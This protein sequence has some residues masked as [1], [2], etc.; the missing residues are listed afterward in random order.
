[1]SELKIAIAGATGFVGTELCLKLLDQDFKLK[2]LSRKPQAWPIEHHHLTKLKGDVTDQEAMNELMKDTDILFY[3]VHGLKSSDKDFEYEEMKGSINANK[4]ATKHKLKKIIYLGGLGPEGHL[5]SHLRSRQLVGEILGS[6]HVPCL[7]FRASIVLGANS[8]SFEMMKAIA[9][10]LP[11]R[12]YAP[13]LESLCQPIGI[14]DLIKY[15]IEGIELKVNG[16]Q[17]VEIGSKEVIPYGELLDRF[18]KLDHL[19]RPKLLVSKVDQ[20]VITTLIDVVVP[21]FSQVGKKLFL[22]LQFPTV[23]TNSK[24]EEFF[25]NIQP[26][27]LDNALKLA[28]QKSLT[29]YPPLWGT[30]FWKELLEHYQIDPESG[31]DFVKRTLKKFNLWDKIKRKKA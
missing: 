27:S 29:H 1:M 8:T 26:M 12:P 22:S 2:I 16:H 5:S 11:V 31:K 14:D 17:I 19:N 6:G 13:W 21:E 28:H 18:L 4:A 24:A 20:K 3:L 23:V 7:E 15:L 25:P 9:H 10:R 30:D